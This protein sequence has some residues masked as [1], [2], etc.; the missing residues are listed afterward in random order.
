M[1]CSVWLSWLLL[2]MEGAGQLYAV[3][4]VGD[5]VIVVVVVH[6][7]IAHGGGERCSWYCCIYYSILMVCTHARTH[8]DTRTHSYAPAI[9]RQHDAGWLV[10]TANAG[11]VASYACVDALVGI[12]VA[13][14]VVALRRC[15]RRGGLVGE[16]LAWCWQY[17]ACDVPAIKLGCG[18]PGQQHHRRSH[19]HD[20]DADAPHHHHHHPAQQ[21]YSY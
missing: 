5:N 15:R 19:T 9:Q 12:W 2:S 16:L 3:C 14:Q 10:G 11:Q 18:G 6:D 21:S 17:A 7:S 13:G 8:S 1:V 4:G 20:M